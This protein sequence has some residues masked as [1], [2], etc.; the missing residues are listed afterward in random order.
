MD[1]QRSTIGGP[2]RGS[3]TWLDTDAGGRI[4]YTA[5]FRWVEM[6]D[7]SLFR[8]LHPGV[9]AAVF[10]RKSVQALYHSMLVFDD[11]FDVKLRIESLGRTSVT[12]TREV[13]VGNESCVEGR[14]TAVHVN[15]DGIPVPLPE[16]LREGVEGEEV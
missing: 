15:A 10:P 16:W 12:F 3:V 11:E 5:A 7:H 2:H 6:A 1:Q 4:H 14:H 13:H 9:N 8:R